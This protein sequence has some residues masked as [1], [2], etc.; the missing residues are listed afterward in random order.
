[1][2]IRK[3]VRQID[4]IV[5]RVNNGQCE[6]FCKAEFVKAYPAALH[7]FRADGSTVSAYMLEG[8]AS[9]GSGYTISYLDIDRNSGAELHKSLC[10][11]LK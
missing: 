7:M 8:I 10:I 2:D 4:D 3:L 1:M 9:T 5:E 11:E 6:E